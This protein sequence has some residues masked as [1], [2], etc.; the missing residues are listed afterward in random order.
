MSDQ[1]SNHQ[2]DNDSTLSLAALSAMSID[3][4]QQQQQFDQNQPQHIQQQY[5]DQPLQLPIITPEDLPPDMLEA[6]NS[7]EPAQQ[8]QALEMLAQQQLL[9]TFYCF[10]LFYFFILGLFAEI[11]GY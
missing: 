6:F 10:V 1:Q 8:V 2:V 5:I 9:G 7:L 4:F 11:V 3:E